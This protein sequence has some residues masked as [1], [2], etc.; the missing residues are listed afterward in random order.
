MPFTPSK[1]TTMITMGMAYFIQSTPCTPGPEVTGTATDVDAAGSAADPAEALPS[2]L[3]GATSGCCAGNWTIT[4]PEPVLTTT[5]FLINTACM[6]SSH[7][8]CRVTCGAA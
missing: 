2:A 5:W 4:L 7:R 3:A 1:A 8:R 6:V